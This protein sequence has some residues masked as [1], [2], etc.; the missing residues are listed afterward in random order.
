MLV[1]RSKGTGR[2]ILFSGA[3]SVFLGS[4]RFQIMLR[5]VFRN[6]KNSL[7]LFPVTLNGRSDSHWTKS[8]T[9]EM[10]RPLL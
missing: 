6:R 2:N 8:C 3:T 4:H 5:L 1:L 9:S 7:N 10:A